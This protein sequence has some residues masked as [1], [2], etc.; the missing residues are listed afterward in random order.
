[1]HKYRKSSGLA[2]FTAAAASITS[3]RILRSTRCVRACSKTHIDHLRS[4][5]RG[6]LETMD[7][8]LHQ[9]F[10]GIAEWTR[11]GGGYFFWLRVDESIDT[12][13]LKTGG[14]SKKQAGFTAGSLFSGDGGLHNH[15]R[16]SFAHYDE[17]DI[18]VGIARLKNAVRLT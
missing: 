1:M 6:R 12:T 11:P 5:Y 3:V 10:D 13:P 8:S 4:T 17:D 15:L 9:H 14:R 18:R 7:E 16:L 2:W